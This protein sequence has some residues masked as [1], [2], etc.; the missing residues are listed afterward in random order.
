MPDAYQG[1][2]CLCDDRK[3]KNLTATQVRLPKALSQ[4]M[5]GRGEH[6]RSPWYARMMRA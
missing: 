6:E 5:D 4:T 1:E 2:C 3:F